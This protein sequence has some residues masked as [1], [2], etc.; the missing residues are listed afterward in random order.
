M[1]NLDSL[2][3]SR[4]ISLPTNVHLVKAMVFPCSHVWLWELD[5]KESWAL[6]DWCYWTV[7]LEKSLES[8]F[9]C[10]EIQ[11]VHPK[12]N[13]SWIFIWRTD[14]EA[15]TSD[16]WWKEV[17][18]LKR[19]W[20]WERLKVGGEGDDRGWDGWMASLTWRTWV[21][22]TTGVVD[23]Q[24]GLACCSP[25]VRKDSDMTG[26]LNWTV[27][28]EILVPWPGMNPYPLHWQLEF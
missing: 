18:H 28:Y 15:E 21:R 25:W 13:Q 1:T 20:C 23:G 3:K 4:D 11:S 19:P 27:A 2:L 24:G 8:P 6:K 9:V 26:Q 12:G 5:Y 16:T 22:V 14:A 7:V 10:K 17:T